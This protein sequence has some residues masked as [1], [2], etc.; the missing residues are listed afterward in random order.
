[1]KKANSL[2]NEKQRYSIRKYH[3]GAA[4]III[5][6]VIFMNTGSISYAAEVDN[7]TSELIENKIHS[8]KEKL[9]NNN[10]VVQEKESNVV[11]DL[12]YNQS[13]SSKDTKEINKEVPL[14]SETSTIA[15]GYEENNLKST[16]SV[17]KDNGRNQQLNNQMTKEESQNQIEHNSK[18]N[19]TTQSNKDINHINELVVKENTNQQGTEVINK[20]DTKQDNLKVDSISDENK[21]ITNQ[22]ENRQKVRRKRNA[23]NPTNNPNIANDTYNRTA[24]N[25]NTDVSTDGTM[26][27]KW[28]PVIGGLSKQERTWMTNGVYGD[29]ESRAR[30]KATMLWLIANFN[31][32]EE[33][34]QNFSIQDLDSPIFGD[35]VYKW[36]EEAKKGNITP[37]PGTMNLGRRREMIISGNNIILSDH[38]AFDRGIINFGD[39]KNFVFSNDDSTSMVTNSNI[40]YGFKIKPPFEKVGVNNTWAISENEKEEIRRAIK[41]ANSD[42]NFVRINVAYNG[43]VFAQA[44]NSSGKIVGSADLDGN[45]VVIDKIFIEKKEKLDQLISLVETSKLLDENLYTPSSFNHL[46]NELN[47]ASIVIKDSYD[48]EMNNIPDIISAT[49]RLDHGI[50]SLVRRANMTELQNAINNAKAQGPFDNSK[51][52][53]QAIISAL[54]VGENTVE[55]ANTPQ[56]VVDSATAN[57][58]NAL[59]RKSQVKNLLQDVENLVSEAEEKNRNASNMLLTAL[60]D[61]IFINDEKNALIELVNS[62]NDKKAEA[63]DKVNL[64]PDDKKTP[65]QNRL[66]KLPII[67][68]PEVNDADGNGIADDVDQAKAQAES[69]VA[70]AEAADQAAKTKLTEYQQDGLITSTEKTDL[71]NLLATAQNTKAE[72]Q[73]LVNKLPDALKG[74][75]PT[76][77]NNLTGIQIPEVNDADGNGIADEV[78]QAKDQDESKVAEAE[79]ADQAAKT[80]LAE[81]QQ[82][83]L[84]TPTE[85]TELNKLSTTAQN[86]KAEAQGLVDALP[87]ALKGDLPTRLNNLTGIQ[88]PEVNDADGNGIADEVDQA[89]SQAENKVAEAEAA[90]QAAKTK[91]AEYQQDGLITPTEVTELN[92][93]STT[94][95]NTKAEAQGLVDA[96]PD[97]LKGDLPTR[98]NNLTGIQ[99]PA[100]N[101]TD[102]NG[103]ADEVDQAKSQA[104]SKVAEAE[105]AD[106]AAKTKLA[107]YQQDG[108]ITPTEVTELNKLS[109]T[110]QNTKAEAQDLVNKLPDALKG[111]LPARVD[112]LTGIQIPE[113]NDADGNGIADEVDQA[114][115][116]AENKVAEAEAADQAAKTRLAEYQQDGVITASEKTDLENLSTTAQNTKAEAQDLVNKLPDALKGDLLTRL[117]NLTGIQVPAV[118]DTDGNGIADEVNQA[119][120]QA[121]SK[122]AEAEA[123]DQAAKTKLAEYQQDDLITPTEVAELENLQATAQSKKAEAQGLVDALP[124]ALKDDLPERLDNLTGIQI[125]EVNDYDGNGFKDD[126][127]DRKDLAESKVID[128]EQA[129][130]I[131]KDKL[132]E[133]QEDSLITPTELVELENLRATA[134]SKK[135]KAQELVDTLPD[136]LKADLPERLSQLKDIHLPNINDYNGNGINDETDR[137]I[138]NA[139]K[140]VINA[141]ETDKAVKAK[142]GEYQ[143]DGLIST[144]EKRELINLLTK[145]QKSKTEV[146]GL[147][148]ALPNEFKGNLPLRLNNLTGIEIP[149]VNDADNDGKKDDINQLKALIEIKVQEAEVAHQNATSKLTEYTRDGLINQWEKNDMINLTHEVF[150]RKVRA[151]ALVEGLPKEQQGE[152][153]NRLNKLENISIPEINDKNNNGIADDVDQAIALAE[154]KVQEAEAAHQ[155]AKN[156]LLEYQ[157]DDL[158]SPT[159]KAE[160]DKLVTEAQNIKAEAQELVVKL[161]D[162]MKGDLQNRLNNLLGIQVPEINDFNDN[163]I[164][165]NSEPEKVQAESRVAQA[166]YLDQAVKDKLSEYQQ[167]GLITPT[168]KAELDNLA[169]I[170]QN[171]KAEA[172]DFVDALPD[173]WKGDLPTRL[174]KLTGI[175]VPAVNDADGNGIADEVDQAKSQAESK[176]AEAEA[177]DQ[178]AKTKLTEY[179]Q[180]GLITSTEKT[181]LENLQST[182][183]SKKA[184]AQDLV[185]KLPDAVKGDLPARLN[186]LTGIQVPEVNDTDGN[187]IADEVDQAKSQAESKVAEAEATDQAAKTKLAEYQ[188]DGVITPTEVAEL[189]KLS[190]T[191]QN[192]KAEAQDLVNKLPGALKGDLPARLNNLTG[193]Q[194]PEVNDADGNGIA[195][196]VDQAKSQAESKVAEAEAADQAAKTKLAEYQQDGV[197]TPTEVAELNKLSTTAQNTKAEAQDLVNKLPD[198]LKGDLPT[199]LNKLTGI[200]VPAVNDADGNGIA[201]EVDQAKSQAES[202]VAEAE[203]ADQAAKTKLTEYQQDGVITASEK[204]DLENLSTTA[205]NKKVEAQDLVNKLPDA[206]KGDLPTRLNNLTGI[207]VPAVN[208]TDGNGIA[209]EVGQAKAQAESKVT[210]AEVAYQV[211][212]TKLSEYQQD[213]VITAVEKASLENLISTAKSKKVEAQ[214]LVNALPDNVKEILQS[215]LNKLEDIVIPSISMNNQNSQSSSSHNKQGKDDETKVKDILQKLSDLNNDSQ[216]S[217]NSKDDTSNESKHTH[218]TTANSHTINT[219]SVSVNSNNTKRVKD[220]N[221]KVLSPSK[222]YDTKKTKEVDSKVLPNTGEETTQ[223]TTLFGT[224]LASLGSLMIWRS[225]KK[226]NTN[227]TK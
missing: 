62:A 33:Q 158:I 92:K 66:D 126:I 27:Y 128:A 219:N 65:F 5:G 41:K 75:L 53:D 194:V 106:Q 189:N 39:N 199:R 134:Q 117:N 3:I 223:N 63:Q 60:L 104:E 52:E 23:V 95:Q 55:N 116:Q 48:P 51:E 139:E 208:D 93:L 202:K 15:P 226:E 170:A 88:V 196:E 210:E 78:D 72:A 152:F 161:P 214:K 147:V 159:E 183:Q 40:D 169:K 125:P 156:K 204:T 59:S 67:S 14:S 141:E 175:Q 25:V 30:K 29:N 138:L 45:E 135:A 18:K 68:I 21:M 177:T 83:D 96:L 4:S 16:I 121:E 38:K 44:L 90:D 151:F 64:L 213:G 220:N 113:V 49:D 46:K 6:S 130:A 205:Q 107:E 217:L 2:F 31:F 12:D 182:A 79:A 84:I 132:A 179:Q 50:N 69:K 195:D 225:R 97:A 162:A 100:V 188:Q 133:Y 99:F 94:A 108:L 212:K 13:S 73:D 28:Y 144:N 119:K 11:N 149:K 155:I 215:R 7:N 77:L 164:M 143:K 9:D 180:D 118:N 190:T 70:E 110:A 1:M 122:V 36:L 101:D 197:I 115:T 178:A 167:N 201:D 176:V 153:L 165:D 192:T 57:I 211:A 102:G 140:S 166:E 109:T 54:E 154:I 43:N 198:A 71:E 145:A 47:Y 172:Q 22:N 82:D 207:Q 200:Q 174:N 85:V 209:D 227:E 98:L 129:N 56:D 187:G 160:L 203:A 80:K 123:A 37:K 216:K 184:E 163:G 32:T 224:L 89:K 42:I 191:A 103:I 114:K 81:Y 186:N 87:D 131:V 148:D 218:I 181:D 137:L 120:S 124:D 168:E 157:Q 76:R 193:I 206:V 61:G 105:A 34:R 19:Q 185:N 150:S 136:V 10:A 17:N 112:N 86:T 24:N 91:L 222:V 8:N 173:V 146:Q 127:D 58:N 20:E 35:D 221:A 171:T 26:T 111:D 74:D 142:L